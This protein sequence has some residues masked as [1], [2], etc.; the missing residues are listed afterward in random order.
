M[1]KRIWIALAAAGALTAACS[2]DPSA[3][4]DNRPPALTAATLG[5]QAILTNAD[6]L[7]ADSYANADPTRG[8]GQ[9]QICRACHSFDK[10]GATM[11]GPNL[12]GMFG[13]PAGFH[14]EYDYSQALKSAD[15]RWTPRAL[16]AWLAEPAKF[17]PGNRM[18]FLGVADPAN[19][20]DLIAYLLRVT[21]DS[22]RE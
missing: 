4:G 16:D 22:M 14:S 15:F 1:K 11:I 20:R 12:Y 17:L 7:R 2:Q 21:D 3:T 6:Y 10:G 19:R 9:A 8:E 13:K 18:S 5:D